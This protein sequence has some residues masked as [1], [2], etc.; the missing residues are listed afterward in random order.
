MPPCRAAPRSIS[1][2]APWIDIRDFHMAI[3]M[4]KREL[5]EMIGVTT[6]AA[7]AAYREHAGLD[8]INLDG[9]ISVRILGR[10]APSL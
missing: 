1:K 4:S 6:A 10:R 7:D 5:P 2:H 3:E 9:F 8:G